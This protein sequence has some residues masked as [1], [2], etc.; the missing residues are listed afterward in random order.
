MRSLIIPLLLFV[1]CNQHPPHA[2]IPSQTEI[3]SLLKMGN[4]YLNSNSADSAL[5]CI[6]KS[7]L[8][9]QSIRDTNLEK[10]SLLYMARVAFK[11]KA[12]KKGIAYYML[13][14]D[15]Y[16]ERNQKRDEANTWME[17]G[18]AL[19]DQDKTRKDYTEII[20]IFDKSL[21]IYYEL[22]SKRDQINALNKLSNCYLNEG[23]LITAN[24]LLE[25][26]LSLNKP[27][28]YNEIHETYHLQQLTQNLQGNID[29]SLFYSLENVKYMS[30]TKDTTHAG[31]YYHFV[32]ENYSA[33]GEHQKSLEW[34]NRALKIKDSLPNTLLYHIVNQTTKEL[35]RL[36]R[37]QEALDLLLEAA[38]HQQAT[39]IAD[40]EEAKGYTYAA[41]GR[42]ELAERH[43]ANMLK[44]YK[45]TS[46]NVIAR[47]KS[48]AYLKIGT[49]YIEQ[50]QYDKAKAYLLQSSEHSSVANRAKTNLMLFKADSA[51]GNF[52]SAIAYHQAYKTLN[53]SIFNAEKNKQIQELQIQYETTK[54]E[55]DIQH[56]QNKNLLQD[57]ELTRTKLVKDLILG[58]LILLLLVSILLYISY[59]RKQKINLTL[60]NQKEEIAQKNR[61]LEVF[62]TEKEWLLK[63]IHHRVKNN[64][65]IVLSLLNTQSNYTNN[66]E[67]YAAIK[68]SQSRL[69]AISL[70]HQKLYKTENPNLI[71]MNSYIQDLV[72]Y[73]K[74]SLDEDSKIQFELDVEP[75]LLQEDQSIPVGLILNEAATN[76]IKYAF[77]EQQTGVIHV[78][79]KNEENHYLM[80]IRDNGIGMP[81]TRS[82]E[83]SSSMG[84]TL[85]KGLSRQLN[86]T[87]TIKN[88]FGVLVQIRFKRKSLSD[89][90]LQHIS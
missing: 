85:I 55:N 60:I 26:A 11:Q 48:L 13:V 81:E 49:F 84:M 33:L 35:L 73:L 69:F 10:K 20:E 15:F 5:H 64:L 6:E 63:E 4:N 34:Y 18:E 41:L 90:Y 79:M 42:Q 58:G 56:L 77:P 21:K 37:K 76:A 67:I 50:G 9:S 66:P 14:I 16:K 46:D 12:T 78:A 27:I 70:I 51:L 38:P 87:F 89:S 17:L 28:Q 32:G 23:K 68:N 22:D 3:D 88:D 82:I 52:K 53:D 71:D 74:E 30:V 36:N 54:K 2:A 8:L 1:A 86:G 31:L 83:D 72:R 7:F 25:K 57:I 44:I 80:S 75:I 45:E 61:A 59:L 24:T 39:G 65:Q 40:I 47:K 29:K 62:L 43:F 19:L